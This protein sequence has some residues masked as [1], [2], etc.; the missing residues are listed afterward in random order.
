M[1]NVRRGRGR[2]ALLIVG[3]LVATMI[4]C[5]SL[6]VGS[7]VQQLAYHYVYLGAGYVDEAITPTASTGN[8]GYFPYSTYTQTETLLADDH[9]I[10]G[11]AP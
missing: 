1:R 6:I 3:L 5:G 11:V 8:G 10:I 2:T 7:T 4:V 9:S